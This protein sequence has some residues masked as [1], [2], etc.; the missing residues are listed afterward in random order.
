MMTTTAALVAM[1]LATVTGGGH[2][3]EIPT[4]YALPIVAGLAAE[5]PIEITDTGERTPASGHE[6][7]AKAPLS[8]HLTVVTTSARVMSQSRMCPQSK[9]MR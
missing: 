3:T 4:G 9:G 8:P 1:G 5:M 2:A 6:P 7:G